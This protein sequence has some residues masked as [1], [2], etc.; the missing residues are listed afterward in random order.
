MSCQAS[1]I[2]L[3]ECWIGPERVVVFVVVAGVVVVVRTCVLM[4]CV[5][6]YPI[7]N[8][9]NWCGRTPGSKLPASPP[10]WSSRPAGRRA[11]NAS[12][13]RQ[14]SPIQSV[15]NLSMNGSE[16]PVPGLSGTCRCMNKGTSTIV[17]EQHLRHLQAI[18][19]CVDHLAHVVH[20]NGHDKNLTK[21]C[22]PSHGKRV[23][24]FQKPRTV[25]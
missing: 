8:A 21:N 14:Q 16:P 15:S 11:K 2:P 24:L 17:Q 18:L 23:K 10:P 5:W 20:N 7:T 6:P 12:K 25:D 3:W 9:P 13:M 4:R 19:H 22:T 1:K